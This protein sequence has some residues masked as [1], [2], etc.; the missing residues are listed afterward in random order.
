[1]RCYVQ[2]HLDVPADAVWM[3]VKKP[4]TLLH[5][6]RGFLD[7]SGLDRTIPEWHEGMSFQTRFWFFHVLPAWWKHTMTVKQIDEAQRMLVSNEHGG[8]ISKWN[9]T[10]RVSPATSGCEYSDEIEIKAGLFTAIVWLYANVFYRYRQRRWRK[11]A[12]KLGG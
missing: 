4:A 2:T 9:H 11:F 7:F 1:M 6:T 3:A 8:I 5:V 12:R 10:I